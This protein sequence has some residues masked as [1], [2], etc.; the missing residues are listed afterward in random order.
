MN[1]LVK[2][3]KFINSKHGTGACRWQLIGF[4]IMKTAKALAISAAI[5]MAG[6]SM[7]QAQDV[8][9]KLSPGSDRKQVAVTIYNE[10]LALIRETRELTFDKGLNRFALRDVSGQIRPETASMV[11]ISGMP[12]QLVEQNFDFDLLTPAALLDK[13]V[14]KE[15]TIVTYNAEQDT[16]RTEKATVL[17]NN[18]G[19]V[20]KYDDRIETGLP[21]S[22]RIQYRDVPQNLR[23]RPTLVTDVV[24]DKA[25]KESVDLSYLTSGL[26]WKADYVA[27]LN[28]DETMLSLAGWVTLTNRSGTEYQNAKLQLVAGDVNRVPEYAAADMMMERKSVQLRAAPAMA[29]ENLFEYHLYTL[30][31]PTTLKN[32]QTKQV[33]LLS[34][35]QVPVKKLYRLSTSSSGY[36]NGYES[37][38]ELGE[39]REVSVFVTFGNNK[40]DNLGL[41]LPKGV[42]R[43]YKPD[44]SGNA[45]FIGEDNIDHTPEKQSVT[46]KLG[47]AFDVTGNWK[48]TNFKRIAK[49]VVEENIEIEVANAKDTPVEI[50]VVEPINDS[51][52]IISESIKHDKPSANAASWKVPVAP[53][54]KTT[55]KFTVR[56][57]S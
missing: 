39:K 13:Y 26:G 56:I 51:W 31:R 55:L 1:A 6:V 36:Y 38:P 42:V 54:D 57:R 17:A 4:E 5:L 30:D 12:L 15:V 2:E 22:A 35:Q 23:D 34:A 46:L 24:S 41:P 43:V 7:T 27:E 37:M 53:K 48:R 14:G 49:N 19:L 28:K 45:L 16:E 11:S 8:V 40:E 20:L 52:E 50:L 32:N 25:G 3:T 9:E 10:S 44:S 29:Q 21:E 18:N 33:A 47:N